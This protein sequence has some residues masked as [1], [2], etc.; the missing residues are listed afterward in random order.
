MPFDGGR[1]SRRRCAPPLFARPARAAVL[2]CHLCAIVS[3]IVLAPIVHSRFPMHVFFN[4]LVLAPLGSSLEALHGSLRFAGLMAMAG[5]A[6]SLVS[7]ALAASWAG[8]TGD[9]NPFY[10]CQVGFSG[11]IF[12]CARAGPSRWPRTAD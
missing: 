7:M 8:L 2:S 11:V 6:G 3:R 1:R 4:M 5:V 12:T 9:T 10:G